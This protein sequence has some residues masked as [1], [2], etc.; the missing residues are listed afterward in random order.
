MQFRCIWPIDSALSG[1]TIPGQSGPGSNGNEEVLWIPQSSSITGASPS[2]CLVSY[3]GHSLGGGLTPM[4]RSNR[5]ILQPQPTGQIIVIVISFESFSHQ[6]MLMVFYWSFSDSKI[7][8]VSRTLPSILTDLYNTV[9][10]K[11]PLVLQSLHQ[12]SSPIL[13]PKFWWLYRAH[14]LQLVSPSISCSIV[15]FIYLSFLLSFSFT[16]RSAGT[17][18]STIR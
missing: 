17:A 4:K 10:W 14:Q 1:A 3:P 15:F 12:T 16:L 8:Q 9:V 5:C 18:R 11:S 6:L 7:P 13:V 2:D